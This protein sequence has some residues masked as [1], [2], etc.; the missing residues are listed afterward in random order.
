VPPLLLVAIA[1][2]SWLGGRRLGALAQ[3]GED[4]HS[5]GKW[6]SLARS[7]EV[8]SAETLSA[9]MEASVAMV[10]KAAANLALPQ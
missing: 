10:P 3:E 7:M 4:P 2:P 9:L 8:G 5:L 6:V 1:K